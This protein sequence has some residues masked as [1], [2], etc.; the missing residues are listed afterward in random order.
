MKKTVFLSIAVIIGL[1]IPSF[2]LNAQHHGRHKHNPGKIEQV[3]T[4]EG[5]VQLV[6]AGSVI[7]YTGV[8]K[9]LK[10][11]QVQVSNYKIVRCQ[12]IS[13]NGTQYMIK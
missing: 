12:T 8:E 4:I 13:V 1:F 11:G 9:T 7:G 5:V 3:T 10:E 6:K 2:A